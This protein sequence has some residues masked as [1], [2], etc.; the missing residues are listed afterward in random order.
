MS[1]SSQLSVPLHGHCG[2]PVQASVI[3]PKNDNTQYEQANPFLQKNAFKEPICG[4][5]APKYLS[6]FPRCFVREKIKSPKNPYAE[7]KVG[8]SVRRQ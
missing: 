8:K 7:L 4:E 5:S 1:S 2:M 6:K 3:R